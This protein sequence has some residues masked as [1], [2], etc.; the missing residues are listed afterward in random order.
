M[1]Y[2]KPINHLRLYI[3]VTVCLA[4][5]VWVAAIGW[6]NFRPTNK[7][8][9]LINSFAKVLPNIQYCNS[10]NPGLALNLYYPKTDITSK[11]PLVVYIHGGGW[12][13][14]D[15]SG[16]LLD[17]YGT[18]FVQKGIAVAAIDYRLDAKNPYPDQNKDIAC[19][20]SYLTDNA[21][22]LSIDTAKIIY[23]GDS[24]GGQLA[25]FAALNIPYD[26]HDYTAPVGVIDFYGVS[27]FSAIINGRRPDLNARRYLGSKYNIV[28]Y[29]ASPTTYVSKHAPR[30]IFFHGTKDTVV[31]IS[32]SK[33]FF[34]QLIA[35]GIDSEFVPIDGAKHAF[36]GPELPTVQY[37][38]IQAN[39]DAF[40]KETINK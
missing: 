27:D 11:I 15:E 10:K 19:A 7:P 5:C 28:A 14:G 30:F 29:Q 36:I 20:L 35:D 16:P 4:V 37:Q 12:L 8:P 31:P 32:Q 25:A 17:T 34:D 21:D 18:K 1:R 24:A 3:V 26:N 22:R 33:T 40:L 38:K 39:I 9:I 6:I 23:F 13:R 2:F